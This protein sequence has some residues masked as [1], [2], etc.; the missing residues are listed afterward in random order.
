MSNALTTKSQ[1]E[2]TLKAMEPDFARTLPPH[3]KVDKFT[4]VAQTAILTNPSLL[5]LERNSLFAACLKAAEDGLLPNGKEAALVPFKGK[6]T[7]MPMVQG[8][9]KKVRNS[10]ELQSIMADIAMEGDE[11]EYWI[12]ENGPHLKHRIDFKKAERGEPVAAYAV[13][14][15]KDG[16]VYIEVMTMEQVKAVKNASRSKDSGPWAGDFADEM[17]KKTVIRRLSKRLPMS[18]DLEDTLARDDQFYDFQ[19]KD[20]E[21]DRANAKTDKTPSRLAGAINAQ[22]KVVKPE[23]A[24][25]DDGTRPQ[26]PE[27]DDQPI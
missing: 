12:D 9:L 1:I 15:T 10:G 17:A 18:T 24:P 2:G 22:S 5:E 6:A 25:K 20:K 23:S 21:E 26:P 16:G 27:E 14:K 3:I 7:Y 11:F 8:I 19:G 4:R 13:A